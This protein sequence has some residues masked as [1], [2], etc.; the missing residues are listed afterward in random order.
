MK[1]RLFIKQASSL[2]TMS[3]VY[4]AYS[5]ERVTSHSSIQNDIN[6]GIIGTGS[7]GTGLA[8]IINTIDGLNVTESWPQDSGQSDKWINAPFFGI[9][10][11]V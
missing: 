11:A 4:P 5:G 2:A 8:S 7:R 1:R 9:V 3:S 10:D 6:I